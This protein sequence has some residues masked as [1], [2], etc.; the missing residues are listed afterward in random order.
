ML[1]IATTAKQERVRLSE[2]VVAGLERAR[3]QGRVGGRPRIKRQH[4]KDAKRIREMRENGESL[5]D[6][7]AQLGR[8]HATVAR[9]C[10]TLNC[11]APE[12]PQ[13]MTL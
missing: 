7:A 2:R 3:K 4:D 5:R 1:G 10:A 9:I 6:I 11:A 12:S 13:A 8:S